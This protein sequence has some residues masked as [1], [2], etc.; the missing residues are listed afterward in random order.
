V[1]CFQNRREKINGKDAACVKKFHVF[2]DW[3]HWQATANK[4]IIFRV[5]QNVGNLFTS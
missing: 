4:L 1:C 2:Q 5:P 3:D